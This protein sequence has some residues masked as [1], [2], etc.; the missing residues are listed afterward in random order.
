M[1]AKA[2]A[3][4]TAAR[5]TGPVRIAIPI[6]VA[7]NLDKFQKA[8]GSLAQSLGHTACFSGADCTFTNMRDWVVDPETLN[9]RQVE[10]L[11]EIR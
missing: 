3:T 11:G 4:A 2:T 1:D 10:G 8:L 6:S 5:V 9:V 7:Y